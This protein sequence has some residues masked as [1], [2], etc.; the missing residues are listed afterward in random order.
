MLNNGTSISQDANDDIVDSLSDNND[1]HSKIVLSELDLAKLNQVKTQGIPSNR[2]HPL[3]RLL[4]DA[5]LTNNFSTF[6]K[7]LSSFLRCGK[8]K[9]IKQC[10]QFVIFKNEK[11]HYSIEGS[12]SSI[13]SNHALAKQVLQGQLYVCDLGSLALVFPDNSEERE[14]FLT[15]IFNS[16]FSQKKTEISEFGIKCFSNDVV[17]YNA[18]HFNTESLQYALEH[19]DVQAVKVISGF[20]NKLKE[21]D[22]VLKRVIENALIKV[23]QQRN[24]VSDNL[25]ECINCLLDIKIESFDLDAEENQLV[26]E[27]LRH[28]TRI[29]CGDDVLLSRICKAAYENIVK[30]VCL[31][32]LEEAKRIKSEYVKS[33]LLE[34][35]YCH[36]KD[37]R[38]VN[39]HYGPDKDNILFV[40]VQSDSIGLLRLLFEKY[41]LDVNTVN[42]Y[43]YTVLHFAALYNA[44][45]CAK[46][47]LESES[48]IFHQPAKSQ[49][50]PFHLAA[51]SNALSVLK[52]LARHKP[53]AIYDKDS[54][55]RNIMHHAAI[56]GAL[57]TLLYSLSLGI[58]V[59]A[60]AI[61]RDDNGEIDELMNAGRSCTALHFA[62]EEGKLGVVN[63]LLSCRDI[64]LSI[65]NSEGCTP[66]TTVDHN[67]GNLLHQC[68]LFNDVGLLTKVLRLG[69][70]GVILEKNCAGQ[71]AFDLA[72]KHGRTVCAGLLLPILCE[73]LKCKGSEWK[74]I[75]ENSDSNG[76]TLLHQ[77][78][79]SRNVTLV[80]K[81]L[82]F[83]DIRLMDVNKD[84]E[85][86]LDIAIK[87][88]SAEI[89]SL[90]IKDNRQSLIS[91]SGSSYIMKLMNKGLM[92][93]GIYQIIK[94][95]CLKKKR[96]SYAKLGVSFIL[97]FV[98]ITCIAVFCI[99][100]YN[101][102]LQNA[103][104]ID[105]NTQIFFIAITV[106]LLSVI[107]VGCCLFATYHIRLTEREK[108]LRIEISDTHFSTAA[109]SSVSAASVSSEYIDARQSSSASST[110]GSG[111]REMQNEI[112]KTHQ[113]A[114]KLERLTLKNNAL[115]ERCGNMHRRP[116]KL[117]HPQVLS[118]TELAEQGRCDI[119]LTS[120]H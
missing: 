101:Q 73:Q 13:Y 110:E 9:R 7:E 39:M 29:V 100:K 10:C 88:G 106:F 12:V 18:I 58:D 56:G 116:S 82:S 113:D 94:S 28:F 71:T 45:R 53:D 17:N 75:F 46:F 52:L 115:Q 83:H 51:G 70:Q 47:L 104:G 92:T 5:S 118:S 65:E 59:N 93:R 2:L 32:E 35:Y 69:W 107:C 117:I 34:T 36:D 15:L 27:K 64:D 62:I 78:I 114:S 61:V 89:I 4:A 97:T 26:A 30:V 95:R 50:T 48:K 14:A 16:T 3:N 96:C 57:D 98:L 40:L 31:V 66:I 19:E 77:A 76:D 80:K 38:L 86:P 49:L 11:G 111:E 6:F 120:L 85:T 33:G 79:L 8:K 81:I 55:G 20:L 99:L 84:N 68:V 119:T 74:K 43:G 1:G 72:I 54:M 60:Q 37:M 63:C 67:G 23:I 90:L 112:V 25:L 102:E 108:L 21:R 44:K 41:K 24:N 42:A 109:N 91:E 87:V 103:F 105:G 22:N